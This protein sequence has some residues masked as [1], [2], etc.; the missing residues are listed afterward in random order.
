MR[1][2]KKV[3]FANNVLVVWIEMG[4]TIFTESFRMLE[5]ENMKPFQNN[6]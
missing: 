5:H 2:S 6:A 4:I 1:Q 3:M